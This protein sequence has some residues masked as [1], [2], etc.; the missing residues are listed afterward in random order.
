[1]TQTYTFDVPVRVAGKIHGNTEVSDWLTTKHDLEAEYEDFDTGPWSPI[2][3]QTK[4]NDRYDSLD[5]FYRTI[6]VSPPTRRYPYTD[7]DERVTARCPA[8]SYTTTVDSIAAAGNSPNF[9][10][11]CGHQFTPDERLKIHQRLPTDL[12]DASEDP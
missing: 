7:S 8:C 11:A 9:C 3:I 1:M 10:A 4:D 12:R 5:E 6:T 2:W